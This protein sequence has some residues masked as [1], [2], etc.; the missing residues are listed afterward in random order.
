MISFFIMSLNFQKKMGAC[1]A[2]LQASCAT[3]QWCI[4]H[5]RALHTGF[6]VRG[7][8][9][10]PMTFECVVCGKTRITVEQQRLLCRPDFTPRE[11]S[12]MFPQ[13]SIFGTIPAVTC[14]D[15]LCKEAGEALMQLQT[16]MSYPIAEI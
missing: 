16:P 9:D 6:F 3:C 10:K 1:L 4:N 5:K 15:I 7:D 13:Y 12:E 2:C 11:M 8:L 14:D